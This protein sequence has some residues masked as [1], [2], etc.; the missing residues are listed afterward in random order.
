MKTVKPAVV[1]TLLRARLTEGSSSTIYMVVDAFDVINRSGLHFHHYVAAMQFDGFFGGRTLNLKERIT[2]DI[3][4]SSVD[5]R[6]LNSV[7]SPFASR[8]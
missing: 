1:N 8:L 4:I 5:Y 6:S 2:Y 7:H 3:V